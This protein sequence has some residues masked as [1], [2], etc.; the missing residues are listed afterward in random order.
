MF[1]AALSQ[2][3]FAS[4]LNVGDEGKPHDRKVEGRVQQSS[5]EH[6][7]KSDKLVGQKEEIVTMQCGPVD[8]VIETPDLLCRQKKSDEWVG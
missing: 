5:R 3:K 8:A 2:L 1:T 6:G 4:P 7:K